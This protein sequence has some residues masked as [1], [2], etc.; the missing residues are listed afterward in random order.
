MHDGDY[1]V[2]YSNE[3]GACHR[4][5]VG[6]I[7]SKETDKCA[8]SN[9]F[10]LLIEFYYINRILLIQS[11]AKP[12]DIIQV[13]APIADSEEADIKEFYKKVEEVMKW[14]ENRDLM[15]LMGDLNARV[16]RGKRKS[17]D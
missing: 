4:H 2:Y 9:Y 12:W 8:I 14:L 3:N 6:M 11:S 10:N 15:I 7:F 17:C 13:Y 5:G 1:V 16:G